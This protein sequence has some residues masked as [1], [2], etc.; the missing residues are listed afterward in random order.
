MAGL[1]VTRWAGSMRARRAESQMTWGIRSWW[2]SEPTRRQANVAADADRST[3]TTVQAAR[4][5]YNSSPA[6][7]GK[8]AARA[9]MP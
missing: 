2:P 7:M 3:T 9:C 6:V 1:N 5:P 4:H 8:T